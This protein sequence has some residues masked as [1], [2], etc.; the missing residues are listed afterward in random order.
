MSPRSGRA[1]R[2][3][4]GGG[5]KPS[6]P[7]RPPVIVR[8]LPAG[9]GLSRLS[10]VVVTAVSAAV[11]ALCLILSTGRSNHVRKYEGRS[12]EEWLVARSDSSAGLRATAAYAL[13]YLW[14][15]AILDRAHIVQAE[16][17]MLGDSDGGVRD[18]AAAALANMAPESRDVVPAVVGVLDRAPRLESRLQAAHTL[19]VIGARAS[20]ALGALIQATSS[21]DAPLRVAAVAAIGRVATR[22]GPAVTRSLIRAAGDPDPEVRASALEAMAGALTEAAELT[23]LAERALGDSAAAVREQAVYA[24]AGGACVSPEARG[25]LGRATADADARVRRAAVAALARIAAESGPPPDGARCQGR[26]PVSSVQQLP[27]AP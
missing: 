24:L 3:A 4:D 13:D 17:Q 19:G 6:A 27:S 21:P 18:A 16:V 8:V 7:I 14:P 20:P 23:P 25:A 9:A 5:R 2:R 22:P 12:A 10:V 11:A 15:V 1:T 26:A